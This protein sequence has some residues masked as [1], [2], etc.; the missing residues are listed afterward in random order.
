[1][2][3]PERGE[4]RAA[5]FGLDLVLLV[6]LERLGPDGAADVVNQDV[7]PPEALFRCIHHP[8]AVGELFEVGG[9]GQ[10]LGALPQL[11]DEFVHQLGAIHRYQPSAFGDETLGHATPDALGRAG[12]DR[13]FV[14]ETFVHLPTLDVVEATH[15]PCRSELVREA[16]C[17]GE[18]GVWQRAAHLSRAS[19]LLQR[20]LER[21]LQA[22][23]A[24]FS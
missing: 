2:A 16:F 23:A 10:H 24:N 21:C 15:K 19:S 14:L 18:P 8:M 20:N 1:M 11:V 12:D 3:A 5:H 9:Q 13:D 6:M 22:L 4:Q 17:C 7:E